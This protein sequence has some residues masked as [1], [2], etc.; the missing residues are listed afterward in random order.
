MP[1]PGPPA[2]ARWLPRTL[3]TR[4]PGALARPASGLARLP[5]GVIPR[6]LGTGLLPWLAAP[7]V[8]LPAVTAGSAAAAASAGTVAAVHR[9][10]PARPAR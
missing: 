1:R 5:G 2:A 4:L 8:S 6:R 9:P 7:V 10:V 3:I